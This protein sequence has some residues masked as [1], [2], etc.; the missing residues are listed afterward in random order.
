M[1]LESGGETMTCMHLG[2]KDSETSGPAVTAYSTFEPIFSQLRQKLEEKNQYWKIWECTKA[3]FTKDFDEEKLD[4][5]L[6]KKKCKNVGRRLGPD[7]D[8]SVL[9][10]A[11]NVT[12]AEIDH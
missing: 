6:G 5:S 8:Y 9:I 2:I 10:F 3:I 11:S 1:G 12:P 7:M 4:I